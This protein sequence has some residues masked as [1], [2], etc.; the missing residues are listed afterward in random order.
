M[1][2]GWMR[3]PFRILTQVRL[4]WLETQEWWPVGE[5]S[6]LK[7][8]S[9]CWTSKGFRHMCTTFLLPPRNNAMFSISC[10]I[11]ICLIQRDNCLT[12]AS[13]YSMGG[14][15]KPLVKMAHRMWFTF[16]EAI[17]WPQLSTI[18]LVCRAANVQ[19]KRSVNTILPSHSF[20]ELWTPSILYNSAWLSHSHFPEEQIRKGTRG[21][22]FFLLF[23]T[24]L[25]QFQKAGWQAGRRTGIAH[26]RRSLSIYFRGEPTLMELSY[27]HFIIHGAKL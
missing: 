21:S 24:S 1:V 13:K 15:N 9:L 3:C 7:Y 11:C 17:S 26:S 2:S 23:T 18:S 12:T 19:I 22:S 10:F 14:S 5:G 8:L 25:I 4:S 6:K 20:Q 27:P 16:C